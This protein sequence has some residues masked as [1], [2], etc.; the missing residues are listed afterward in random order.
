MITGLPSFSTLSL[1]FGI[2]EIT[3]CG[4]IRQFEREGELGRSLNVFECP[5]AG[6]DPDGGVSLPDECLGAICCRACRPPYR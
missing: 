1:L 6:A 4:P 3:L 2:P 5:A